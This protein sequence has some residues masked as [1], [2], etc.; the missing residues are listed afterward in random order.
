MRSIKGKSL[1]AERARLAQARSRHPA[2]WLDFAERALDRAEL[3]PAVRRQMVRT[4][5]EHSQ[6]QDAVTEQATAQ[7]LVEMAMNLR[8]EATRA[9]VAAEALRF[10]ADRGAP[11]QEIARLGL[12]LLD[13]VTRAGDRRRLCERLLLEGPRHKDGDNHHLV[14]SLVYL[15]QKTR[16]RL[17]VIRPAMEWLA[18]HPPWAG[19]GSAVE[20]AL[21]VAAADPALEGRV[22][23]SAV[24]Q[25]VEL[26]PGMDPDLQVAWA[27]LRGLYEEEGGQASRRA[28]LVHLQ[29]MTAEELSRYDA[30]SPEDQEVAARQAL[31]E[32]PGRRAEACLKA[33]A[34]QEVEA[35]AGSR[36]VPGRIWE[37]EDR[38]VVGDVTLPRRG[39]G[40]PSG[41]G[42]GMPG[43]GR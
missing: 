9:R 12:S 41:T 23:F 16:D 15:P 4:A 8:G 30:L 1:A 34:R 33:R 29:A 35:L 32:L 17:A 10:Q 5:L 13:H 42:R 20:L 27:I 6:R 26:K 3:S 18:A 7:A 24:E 19:L 31:R 39:D 2:P 14:H 37:G 40:S 25:M 28:L 22:L 21:H 38:V 36:P 43:Q 11:G